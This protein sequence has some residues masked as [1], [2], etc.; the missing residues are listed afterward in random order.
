MNYKI[1]C[2]TSLYKCEDYLVNFL[3]QLNNIK[4]NEEIEYIFIHNDP[5]KQETEIINT[6]INSHKN[7]NI[8][9]VK[10]RRERLYTSWNR[11]IR[12]AT[13]KY[14]TIWNVDDIRFPKSFIWQS[15]L[16]DEYEGV[17]LVYGNRY[18]SNKYHSEE[19]TPV[20]TKCISNDKW[21]KKF[22]G[23]CF[24]MWRKTIH[25]Q[26]GYFDEQFVS[27]GDQDFWY[28]MLENFTVKKTEKYLGVFMFEEGK[29][30][31]KTSTLPGIEKII[32]GARYG[33]FTYIDNSGWIQALRE[34]NWNKISYYDSYRKHTI[35]K[36]PSIW[37]YLYSV[38]MILASFFR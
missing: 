1:S 19:L 21:F 37:I 27:L 11:A 9:Y 3:S 36:Y 12:I 8:S 4:N 33:F 26:I 23:G 35:F 30:I 2:I 24:Y 20:E 16:L 13:G 18:I 25:D 15:E 5:T 31:S 28:R 29:G 34:Y 10:V 32:I 7:I 17:G 14:I 22:Q 6:F 38:Y